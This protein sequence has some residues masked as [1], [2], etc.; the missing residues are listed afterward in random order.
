MSSGA[1]T[2]YDQPTYQIELS[3]STHYE[4]MKGDTTCQKCDGL[5]SL[6]VT[7]NSA[8]RQSAYEFLFAFH[9]NYVPILHHF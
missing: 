7:E 8:I 2:C 6:K 9:S 1:S 4:D 5:G 3:I